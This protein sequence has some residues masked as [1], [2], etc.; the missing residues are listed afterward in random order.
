M[1]YNQD[2]PP[3]E[4]PSTLSCLQNHVEAKTCF[5]LH[6]VIVDTFLDSFDLPPQEIMLDRLPN[7]SFKKSVHDGLT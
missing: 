6:E 4:S 3:L 5:K 2:N 1:K 7:Y